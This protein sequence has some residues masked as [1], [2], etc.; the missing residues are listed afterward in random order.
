[1]CGFQGCHP[2]AAAANAAVTQ[3]RWCLVTTE[4]VSYQIAPRK[5]ALDALTKALRTRP[6][7]RWP[8]H[9][10]VARRVRSLAN[11]IMSDLVKA[12]ERYRN[13]IAVIRD[14]LDAFR[15][16]ARDCRE[17]CQA[18]RRAQRIHNRAG[19]SRAP[20]RRTTSASVRRA[21]AD[22]GGD[23]DG[24]PPEPRARGPPARVGLAAPKIQASRR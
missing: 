9:H 11:A 14:G 1:M 3:Q 22:T 12:I 15:R 6:R 24:E 18:E 2:G 20:G 19:R 21:T 23:S 5:G 7:R 10:P 13:S 17:A 8:R 16:L 4:T